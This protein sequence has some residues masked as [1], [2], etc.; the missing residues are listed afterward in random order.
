MTSAIT[1]DPAAAARP[2]VS[3]VRVPMMMRLNMS[4]PIRSV[5]SRNSR[6]GGCSRRLISEAFMSYG[7]IVSAN[8]AVSRNA[9]VITSPN[10]PSG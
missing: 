1:T 4:R 3:E 2:M 9:T 8:T 7:A 6:L 10:A 5:P